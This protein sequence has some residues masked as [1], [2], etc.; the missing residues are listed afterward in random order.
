MRVRRL[1]RIEYYNEKS[2]LHRIDGPARIWNNGDESWWI[3]G[4]RHRE[5]GPA[6]QY[7]KGGSHYYFDDVEYS[8]EEWK[9]ILKYK[10]FA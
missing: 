8:F 6:I 7:I 5:D 3:N 2:Q 9:E 10:V 1:N 4:K